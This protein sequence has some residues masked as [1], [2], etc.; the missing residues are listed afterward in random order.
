MIAQ[1]LRREANGSP[2]KAY[3][4]DLDLGGRVI[5]SQGMLL[6]QRFPK[7]ARSFLGFCKITTI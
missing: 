2:R 7:E 5:Q 1:L 3:G 6:D 4:G